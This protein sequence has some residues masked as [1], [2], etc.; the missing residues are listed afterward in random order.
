MALSWKNAKLLVSGDLLVKHELN[1]IDCR[2]E[3]LQRVCSRLMM[4]M[5]VFNNSPTQGSRSRR[6]GKAAKES[7]LHSLSSL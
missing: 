2:I 3:L 4:M 5:Q 6:R 7:L 1:V